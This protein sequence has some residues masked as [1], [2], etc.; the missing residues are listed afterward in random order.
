MESVPPSR[1]AKQ[2]DSEAIAY[3][4]QISKENELIESFKVF[5]ENNTGTIHAS[6]LFEILTQMGD[7][8]EISEVQEMFTDMG[9][10]LDLN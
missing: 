8:L 4:E 10:S 1:I 2:P 5:D 3:V 6:K 7:P 9:I